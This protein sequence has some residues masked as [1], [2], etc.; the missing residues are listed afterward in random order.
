MH[1]FLLVS[2]FSDFATRYVGEDEPLPPTAEF[3]EGYAMHGQLSEK[4]AE[5]IP[6]MINLRCVCGRE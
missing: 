1:G 5:C 4:E 2:V 3:M 6:D